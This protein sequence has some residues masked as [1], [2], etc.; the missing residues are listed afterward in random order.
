MT[1]H[2][3]IA[4]VFA[5]HGAVAGSL[6][7]RIPWLQ[8]HFA[9]TPGM[10][11]L[12]LLCQP[13]GAFIGMPMASHLAYRIGGRR[14]TRI[15]I[16]LWCVLVL[17][18]VMAPGP[19]WLFGAFLLLGAAAGTSDVVMNAHAVVLE[20]KLG[21]SIIAGLHGL[22]SVGSLAAGG[23][24]V[25]AA[26][27]G[28]D[29][30]LHL[31]AVAVLLLGLSTF[32]GR[33]LLADEPAAA[34][35]PAPRRFALPTRAIAAIGLVGFCGTFAEGAS[36]NWAAVYVTQV[37]AAAPAAAAAT[38][39]VFMLFMAGTRLLGDRIVGRFGAVGVVR[40]GGVVA[41]VGGV[42]VVAGRTTWVCAAGFALIGIGVA[43]SAPLAYAAAGRTGSSPG[44]GVAGVTTITY[45]SSLIAP[46]VIGGAADVLSYPAAFALIIVVVL[47]MG[48]LAGALRP[49]PAPVVPEP[50][51]S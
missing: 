44:E 30:R 34:G 38:Y 36:A 23:L 48:V 46:A 35:E 14:A 42:L 25:L 40:V 31:A 5:T 32:A 49:R 20:R 7:T 33:G 26:H 51:P 1:N 21:R 2:R 28:I 18:P 22:W 12:V 3:A 17:A 13:I 9:L 11:G 37:A 16:A 41:A 15:L 6:S 19:G 27:L 47:L 43:V 8:D 50:C 24:G 29:A 39:T 4:L 10:L 45:L